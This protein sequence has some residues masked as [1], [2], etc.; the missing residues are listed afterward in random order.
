MTEYLCKAI[1]DG[2]QYEFETL[3]AVTVPQAYEQFDSYLLEEKHA[4]L[5]IAS[6][7]EFERIEM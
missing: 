2:T 4:V 7:T 6:H 3:G 1:I 5:A